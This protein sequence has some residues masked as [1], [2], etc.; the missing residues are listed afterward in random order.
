MV[1]LDLLSL[2]VFYGLPGSRFIFWVK[3]EI[4]KGGGWGR[5]PHAPSSPCVQIIQFVKHEQKAVIL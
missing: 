1:Y 2:Y 5:F 3:F 4:L